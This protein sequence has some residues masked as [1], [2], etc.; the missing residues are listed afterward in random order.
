MTTSTPLSPDNEVRLPG[1][2]CIFHISPTFLLV[3]WI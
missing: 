2:H 1:A 3:L